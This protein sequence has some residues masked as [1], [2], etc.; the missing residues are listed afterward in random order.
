MVMEHVLSMFIQGVFTQ[1]L[2]L[3]LFLG[4][5]T[6][7]AIAKKVNAAIGLGVAVIVVQSITLPINNL[8]YNYVLREGALSWTGVDAL[9]ALDL[10][11]LSFLTFIGVIAAVVQVLEMVLDRFFPRLYNTLGIFLPLITV[12]CAI[13]GGSLFMQQR[14]YNFTDS[15]LYGVFSG[16]GW[17]VAVV[18]FAGINE[19]LEYSQIPKGLRGLG[20]SFMAAGLLS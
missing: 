3:S 17:A 14:D 12:N 20:V 13:M 4:M 19:K 9:A 5:C 8:L 16:L 10:N 15:C 6:L 1:N 18:I 11:F 7:L 2:A